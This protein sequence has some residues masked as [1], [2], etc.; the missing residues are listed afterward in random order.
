VKIRLPERLIPQLH[1]ALPPD[2]D[3]GT[4]K[5]QLGHDGVV[6]GVG[7]DRGGVIRRVGE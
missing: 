3:I 2:A 7:I 1:A 6:Y 5:V 4:F